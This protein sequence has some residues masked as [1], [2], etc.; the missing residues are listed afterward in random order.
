MST[1][2]EILDKNGGTKPRM[3]FG[4]LLGFM[5]PIF[6]ITVLSE[7]FV[8]ALMMYSLIPILGLLIGIFLG[9]KKK[10]SSAKP[11][12]SLLLLIVV[13]FTS[14]FFI[15]SR[16]HY[17]QLQREEIADLYLPH[18]TK[19]VEVE[20]IYRGGDGFTTSPA[21]IIKYDSN[22]IFENYFEYYSRELENSGWRSFLNARDSEST[23]FS[24]TWTKDGLFIQFS[25]DKEGADKLFRYGS[26]IEFH[27]SWIYDIVFLN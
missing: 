26:R 12:V 13:P 22:E 19:L 6:I 14:M 10:I 18:H 21:V 27:N 2:L 25:Q 5:L 24:Q 8:I 4:G 7:H 1:M 3:L 17:I 11:L 20:R 15:K 9:Y 23:R 16:N